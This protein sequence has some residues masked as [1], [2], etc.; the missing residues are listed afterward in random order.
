METPNKVKKWW[1]P[2]AVVILIV[3]SII[4]VLA[5]NKNKIDEAEKPV[6]RTKLPVSVSI[7]T[8]H[9]AAMDINT[10]YPALI[11]PLDE[12]LLYAQTSGMI[13]QLDIAL[14]KQVRKGQVV[15]RLDTRILEINL[16]NAQISQ[17]A[18][19][20]NRD[21]LADDYNRA[22]DLY[23]NKAGLEISMLTAKNNYENAANSYDNTEVQIG[24]IKQQIA[25]ANIVAPLSGTVSMHKVKQGEFVNPGT[26]IAAIADISKLKTTVFVDQQMSYELKIGETATI[27]A[28]LFGDQQFTGKIIFISPVADANHNYQ[29]DLLVS[30]TGKILLRGGTD[31]QVS[32]NTISQKE[33]LQIP[34]A[35]IM[36]DT[37]EPYVFVA[38]NGKA[39]TKNIKTGLLQ[40][41]MAQ[42]LAGLQPG[43]QVITSGQINLKNGSIVHILN[44]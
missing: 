40:Q 19:A 15:G 4:I 32:F 2:V 17:R 11:Q 10:Q 38:E 8:A 5:G 34:R 27:S 18:A 23:Q 1:L 26:P 35:A 28:P 7:A 22:I 25:N 9:I 44:K 6:D 24:L 16:K 37:R 43:E 21:K 12:A 41:N 31:V 42:V 29:V 14:G 39:I 13:A 36:T 30:Q 20:I 3:L 33:A